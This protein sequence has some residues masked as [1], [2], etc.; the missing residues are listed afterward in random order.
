MKKIAAY[1][2]NTAG[3]WEVTKKI[4]SCATLGQAFLW[5][6]VGGFKE[7]TKR[8]VLSDNYNRLMAGR[9]SFEQVLGYR[10]MFDALDRGKRS[11]RD[12]R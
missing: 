12:M 10:E 1:V 9:S 7:S 8:A 6:G 4:F 3:A 5:G 2:G 11:G